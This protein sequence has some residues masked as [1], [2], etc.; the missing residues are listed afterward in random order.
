MHV[1]FRIKLWK[2]ADVSAMLLLKFNMVNNSQ[3]N[4]SKIQQEA[5]EPNWA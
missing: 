4:E 3:K 2:Y 5:H 1:P